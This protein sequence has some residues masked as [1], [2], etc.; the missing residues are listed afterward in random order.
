MQ[1]FL[2]VFFG[3]NKNKLIDWSFD[4]DLT[5]EKKN[6]VCIQTQSMK[7]YWY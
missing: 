5:E 4:V 2:P 1:S 6:C 3:Y 7:Y